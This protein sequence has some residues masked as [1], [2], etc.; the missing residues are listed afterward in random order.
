MEIIFNKVLKKRIVKLI[1]L[2][3]K[4]LDELVIEIPLSL[5]TYQTIEYD[6]DSQEIVLHMFKSDFDYPFLFDD[7]PDDDKL[8]VYQILKGI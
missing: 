1:Y 3:S 8:R 7:L 2:Y 5:G 4:D 6:K